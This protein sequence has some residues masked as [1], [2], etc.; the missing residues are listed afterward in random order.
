MKAQRAASSRGVALVL[1]L[2]VVA[3][4][5]VLML[6]INLT[7]RSHVRQ[8]QGVS[9]RIDAELA[10]QSREAV[11]AFSLLTNAWETPKVRMSSVI[12]HQW[13]FSGQPFSVD[14]TTYEI[15]D[16]A[17]LRL[18]PQEE[19]A[20]PSFVPML[21]HL[22][23]LSAEASNAAVERLS[24]EMRDPDW[25]LLQSFSDLTTLGVLTDEQVNRLRRFTTLYPNVVFNP[26]TAPAEVLG[27]QFNG[28]TLEAL[29]TARGRSELDSFTFAEIAGVDDEFNSFAPSPA[30]NVKARLERGEA[31]AS[32]EGIWVFNPYDREPLRYWS[33]QRVRSG[34]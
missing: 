27:L 33:R 23:G 11:L 5:S 3:T 9:D 24:V 26:L 34:L 29:L 15:Q 8:A 20:L 32:Q 4:L 25:V 19:S 30:L 12:A 10:L 18:L 17:G 6:Q 28:T 13:N 31:V 2:M 21:Q 14:D 7:S 16:L 22:L 1:V